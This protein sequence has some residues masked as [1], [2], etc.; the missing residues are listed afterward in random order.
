MNH[1]EQEGVGLKKD[2]PDHL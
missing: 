2:I 1:W